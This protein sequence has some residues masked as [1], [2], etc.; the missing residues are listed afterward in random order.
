[1]AS[2][3]WWEEAQRGNFDLSIYGYGATIPHV[4]DYWNAGFKT[5][6]GYNFYGYANPAFDAIVAA[7]ARESDPVKLQALIDQGIAIL[8]RD[9]PTTVRSNPLGPLAR[10]DN[11]TGPA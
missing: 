10:L 5:G 11:V 6:G 3:V 9:Q 8:D 7:T 1:V 4:A 2:G